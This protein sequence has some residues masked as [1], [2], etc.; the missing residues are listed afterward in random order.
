M[1]ETN[2]YDIIVVGAGPAGS[3]A[4]Y[5]AVLHKGHRPIRVCL[6][7]RNHRAGFPVRCG[8]GIG[9]KGTIFNDFIVEEQW[10]K[11]RVKTV[12]LVS[13]GGTI[14]QLKKG[15][16]NYI[17]DRAKMDFDLVQKAIAAGVF[18][19]SNTS[20]V[21]VSRVEKQLYECKSVQGS[22]F[23]PCIILADGVESRLARGLGWN[24]A[25]PLDDID[26]CAFCRISHESIAD[27]T[28]F[29]Y[30]GSNITPAGFAWVFPRGNKNAN[31]GIGILG[32][33]SKSGEAKNLL[34]KFI[35]KHFTGASI[36]DI[37]CGGV[38]A[39]RWLKPLVKEGVMIVGD[40][41]RQVISLSGAGIN[42]AIFSGKL[43]G[44]TAAASYRDGDIDYHYLFNYEKVWSAGLG[45]QQLRS[46]ALKTLLVKKNNDRFIESIAK[47]LVQKQNHVN[48][49]FLRVF[50]RT[51]ISNPL[52][53]FKAFL[54]FK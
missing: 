40:A 31:V 18:Y 22:F 39:G 4:A 6:L 43:A 42:Y 19:F 29:F 44:K 50:L 23:A 35:S 20:V 5:S 3:M 7:E 45:K 28:C 16:E 9:L 2:R 12:C 8:E 21:S 38:P 10:I 54:L 27:D 1:N 11:A 46:F 15:A 41:A 49:S 33:Y 48:L 47:S 24:T 17:V 26:C 13:P 30:T 25:L 32:S 37:H 34:D 52:A 53:F 51:F 14:V 36:S